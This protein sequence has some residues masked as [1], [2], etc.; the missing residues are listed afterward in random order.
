M[1]IAIPASAVLARPVM[2]AAG[3]I[4]ALSGFS[5]DPLA[6]LVLL[7]ARLPLPV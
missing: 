7:S 5:I 2:A 1:L 4:H 6:Y 3:P